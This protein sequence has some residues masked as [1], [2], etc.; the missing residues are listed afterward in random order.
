MLQLILGRSGTGKTYTI[1]EELSRLA[2]QE[3]DPALILLVPE[4]FSFESERALL[5]R[6][7]PRLAG[8]IQVLS[9]TRLAETVFRELGG[10]AGQRMDESTRLLLMSQALDQ[11]AEHLVLYRRQAASPDY[12]EAVLSLLLECKQCAI[13]PHQLEETAASLEPGTLRSKMTELS[14]ILEAYEALASQSHIDPLDDLTTLAK[15]LPESRRLRGARIF[16][17]SFKGFTSQELTILGELLSLAAQVTVALCTDTIEDRQGGFGLFSPVIRTAAR[18]REMAYSRHIPVAKI[19]YLTTPRRTDSPA[20]RALEAGAFSPHPDRLETPADAVTVVPCAD[21]YEECAY[22]ARTIRRL[23]R[24]NG[25]RCRDIAIVARN[26]PDYEGLLDVALEQEGIPYYMDRRKDILTE[27]LTSL[28]L[29]ALRIVIDGWD[30]AE[31]LQLI[32]TGLLPDFSMETAAELENYLY[33]WR[34]RGQLWQ[35]P[36]EWNPGGLSVQFDE[37]ARLTLDKLNDWRERLTAPLLRLQKDFRRMEKPTGEDFAAAIYRYL[38]Q[39]QA[40]EAV[41]QQVTRLE[42]AGEPELA[43]RAARM[44]DTW[45][46]LLSRYAA[47]LSSAVL[48]PRR[49]MELLRLAAGTLDLGSIPQTLDAVQVGSADR[50]RLSSPE[51]VFLLGV[52]EGVFPAYPQGAGLLSDGERRRLIALGLPMTEAS[53]L[54]AVEERFFAYTALSAPSQR[55]F[56]SY[57]QGNAAGEALTP[58]SLVD[59]VRFILPQC[60]VGIARADHAQDVESPAEAFSRMAEETS[61]PTPQTAAVRQLLLADPAWS[62]RIEILDR[63]AVRAPFSFSDPLLAR[64]FFGQ[65]LR[66]SPSQVDRFY[67]CSFSYFCQYGMKAKPRRAADLDA[68][69]FGTLTHYVMEKQLKAYTEAQIPWDSLLKPT[70]LADARAR[71]MD[72]VNDT[73][74]GLENKPA[75][76]AYLVDRLI[77]QCG[78]LLWRV[79]RELAQSRFVP[80]AYELPIGATGQDGPAVEPMT[81]AL[82]DGSTIQVCGVVDRL[83]VFEQNGISYVRIIDYKTGQKVFRLSDVVEGIHIQMLLYL[84]SICQHGAPFLQG[85]PSEQITPASGIQ[86][87]GVL[88]LP[89]KIPLVSMYR[90]ASPDERERAQLKEMRMNGLLLDHPDILRA[91]ETDAAG[92]FIPVSFKKDGTPKSGS[93]LASLQQFG[94]LKNKIS[95]LLLSMAASLRQGEI[96]AVPV[97]GSLDGC[98]YCPY[99]AVCRHEADDPVRQLAASDAA[100]VWRSLQEA[101]D[102]QEGGETHE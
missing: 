29:C 13:S 91:M 9:F 35:E 15:R 47:A 99:A 79:V 62:H 90:E 88:Y 39:V 72:Y 51:T 44:W 61:H 63:A 23:L 65:K 40:D 76:F 87:A 24:E 32:K 10:L 101:D 6:L 89:A 97:K 38:T 11:V 41:R 67:Q 100:E 3:P 84:F 64:Q 1:Y 36:W 71:V 45:M 17:D 12:I 57:L 33:M 25:G 59:T 83:D 73:M 37:A 94:Q 26:L 96:A 78:Q 50:M 7:G 86:P 19:R 77:Q 102:A 69:E 22:V 93:S 4:Q 21:L 98:A 55:L 85:I 49:H 54:Q 8:R 52:N 31:V 75:R 66:L 27:P 95:S 70:V 92:I 53:D 14:L 34:I 20:L 30:T 81:L 5:E 43:E 56:I 28:I 16:V 48:P 46:E 68:L 18:L 42:Q 58:S 74:G 60:A 80:V 2:A 82:P